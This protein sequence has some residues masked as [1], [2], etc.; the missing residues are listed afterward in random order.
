MIGQIIDKMIAYNGHDTR[1]INHALK[2]YALAKCIIESETDDK[3]MILITEA[4]AVL[5]DIGI[6]ECERKYNSASGKY[7]EI[8]G[9]PIAEKMLADMQMDPNI[10]ERVLYL[11]A[12]HH[13]YSNIDGLDYQA[14]VEAD[15]IV[16]LE[17][18][19]SGEGAILAALK[20][21]F[22]TDTG[23]KI[24]KSMLA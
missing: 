14:L 3:D 19:K 10:I 18:E 7:Q 1:R 16:N 17:E 12:H 6:H 22:K 21:I 5:H 8:E 4:A 2:V 13:T 9:P 20:N 11:I 15:F 23:I 24:L